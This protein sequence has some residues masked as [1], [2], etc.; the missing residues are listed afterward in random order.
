MKLW[1]FILSRRAQWRNQF[2][3]PFLPPSLQI[4]LG[5]NAGGSGGVGETFGILPLF[6]ARDPKIATHSDAFL[7]R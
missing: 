1:S 7:A 6:V 2:A 4:D 3:E 5:L